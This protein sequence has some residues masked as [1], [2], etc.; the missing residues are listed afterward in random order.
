M[1]KVIIGG[2]MVDYREIFKRFY[3]NSLILKNDISNYAIFLERGISLCVLKKYLADGE[4]PLGEELTVAKIFEILDMKNMK[5]IDFSLFN[6]LVILKLESGIKILSV[7]DRTMPKMTQVCCYD[8]T[9]VTS[10][11]Y[12]SFEPL[13][14]LANELDISLYSVESTVLKSKFEDLIK[15]YV[16]KSTSDL[17]LLGCIDTYNVIDS[18]FSIDSEMKKIISAS[19]T[20]Q[21]SIY[22]YLKE[23]Y[24]SS[25]LSKYIL[26][27]PSIKKSKLS[28]SSLLFKYKKAE[29]VPHDDLLTD[30]VKQDFKDNIARYIAQRRELE[31][32]IYKGWLDKGNYDLLTSL[33]D[34]SFNIVASL[35]EIIDKNSSNIVMKIKEEV[36]FDSSLINDCK[37]NIDTSVDTVK[38]GK[39][40]FRKHSPLIQCYDENSFLIKSIKLET[41]SRKKE[42]VIYK[43][44][45]KIYPYIHN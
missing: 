44:E 3:E 15:D 8:G 10:N 32:F 34:D 6:N 22:D 21:V 38:I 33:N 9:F 25:N 45:V 12:S 29:L 28:M 20:K 30:R 14:E 1:K 7:P 23:Y 11:E 41:E 39:Y 26:K 5:N 35:N 19:Y 40:N 43:D 4:I 2:I 31:K 16:D 42:F 37:I 17:M 36:L 18:T 24:I 13:V 27:Y